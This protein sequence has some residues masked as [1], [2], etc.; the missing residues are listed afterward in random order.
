MMVA[1]DPRL[2][3]L[4][5][6]PLPFVSI[7][8]KLFGSA[9]H[10]RFEQI[11][12]Q[13]SDV[14]A[15]A[16]ES[17]VRRSRGARLPAGGGRDRAVSAVERRVPAPQPAPDRPAELL[18]SGHVAAARGGSAPGPLARQPRCDSWPH[19]AGAVRG[20][21]RVPDDAELAHDR[22][23]LGDQHA[24]AGDGVVEA[25]ARSARHG[26]GHRRHGPPVGQ[27]RA[28]RHPVSVR[29]CPSAAAS[30][31]ATWCFPTA[32]PASSIGCPRPSRPA[33]RWRWSA[34]RAPGSPR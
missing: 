19:H 3:L 30:N 24:A 23:R 29:P 22:V 10:R 9:I 26:S 21:Q 16:H 15:V 33:R 17:P 20:V 5:L 14:S 25:H 2:T 12:A 1:I 34:S 32:T 13:L 8:V 28:P 27:R 7:S 31:S 11:Q 4:S 6:L 18:L